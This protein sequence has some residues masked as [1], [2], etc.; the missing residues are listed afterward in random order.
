YNAATN[1]TTLRL[2]SGLTYNHIPLPGQNVHL[3][4]LTRNV[5]FAS[6]DPGVIDHRAHSMFHSGDVI[7][8]NAAFVKM[9]R[10]DKAQPLN[11]YSIGP[12]ADTFDGSAS[13]RRG[14]YP[15]HFHRTLENDL[16]SGLRLA[17]YHVASV[18]GCVVD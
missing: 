5:Q 16:A 4:N 6:A 2:N 7:L 17:S 3:A 10:T 15:I 12:T 1:V 14:R 18:S 9:G 8:K 11:D 13:N